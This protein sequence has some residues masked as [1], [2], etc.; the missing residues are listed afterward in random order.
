MESTRRRSCT[1]GSL[2]A[3]MLDLEAK[4]ADF[5]SRV[6]R[7][8]DP[9]LA[10]ARLEST[11]LSSLPAQIDRLHRGLNAREIGFE[12]LPPR[13]VYASRLHGAG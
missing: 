3:S 5:L 13:L 9:R 6:D 11:L 7:D 2:G 10:L 8:E 4:L 1:F 12:R